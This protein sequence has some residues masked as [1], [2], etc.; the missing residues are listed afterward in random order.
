MPFYQ[1]VLVMCCWFGN[2]ERSLDTLAIATAIAVASFSL[3]SLGRP[4]SFP[5]QVFFDL[6]PLVLGC[7]SMLLCVRSWSQSQHRIVVAVYGVILAPVTFCS[8][9]WM[10]L[11]WLASAN[12]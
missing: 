2:G 9:G 5:F 3:P 4:F 7:L 6:M 11:L 12:R 8:P 10:I 1:V